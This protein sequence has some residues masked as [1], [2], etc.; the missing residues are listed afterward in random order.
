M[1]DARSAWSRLLR[2]ASDAPDLDRLGAGLIRGLVALGATAAGAWGLSGPAHW[3]ILDH[4]GPVPPAPP[5]GDPWQ[6]HATRTDHRTVVLAWIATT[7]DQDDRSAIQAVLDG[8]V[9][10]LDARAA[11]EAATQSGSQRV[12]TVLDASP[13]AVLVVDQAGQVVHANARAADLFGHSLTELVGHGIDLL[14]PDDV[15]A[16]HAALRAGYAQAPSQRAMAAGQDLRARHRDGTEFP[17]DIALA[18]IEADG[19]SAVA[20][21]VRDATAR[22]QAEQHRRRLHVAELARNQALELNDNIVQ[23]LTASTWLLEMDD[24]PQ[25]LQAMRRTLASARRMMED[26]L[27]DEQAAIRPGR[28]R[29]SRPV[30]A[31]GV[32]PPAEPPVETM[33]A[34]L[35]LVVADDSEDIRLL[36]DVR[37]RGESDLEVVALATDGLEA[38]AAV[39]EHRP[40]VILMDLSM[41]R[42]DGLQATA[43]IRARHPDVRVVVLTG[44]PR[45]TIETEAAAAGAD[46][47]AEKGGSFEDLLQQVRGLGPSGSSRAPAR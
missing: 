44:H 20:V 42:L 8:A 13:D 47:V 10:R 29:R 4:A 3:R 11:A 9:R 40:D 21:F 6:V 38:V 17:V 15:R 22:H 23:G 34:P 18:P 7:I 12:A 24:V 26:L 41:P 2:E 37:L 46:A 19:T 16:R 43:Q 39:D 1:T 5:E 30:P 32:A 14:V 28:L 33:A 35:R 27:D 45:A 25:A 31:A 36:M